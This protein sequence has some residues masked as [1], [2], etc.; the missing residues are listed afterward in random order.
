MRKVLFLH[1]TWE[2]EHYYCFDQ[3][4]SDWRA[5]LPAQFS[6]A[7]LRHKDLDDDNILPDSG[8]V[9]S[10]VE[11]D[12]DGFFL[13]VQHNERV[14]MLKEEHPEWVHTAFDLNAL[15]ERVGGQTEIAALLRI[16]GMDAREDSYGNIIAPYNPYEIRKIESPPTNKPLPEAEWEHI[17]GFLRPEVT[18][19][20]RATFP[21]SVKKHRLLHHLF[22]CEHVVGEK[23]RKHVEDLIRLAAGDEL[24]RVYADRD[25][26]LSI[27]FNTC[28]SITMYIPVQKGENLIDLAE[29]INEWE[30]KL[31]QRIREHI[32]LSDT[33]L[34][35]VREAMDEILALLRNATGSKPR[36]LR[37]QTEHALTKTTSIKHRLLT[38][39]AKEQWTRKEGNQ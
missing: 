33:P 23:Y 7:K 36:A 4:T 17:E 13:R 37:E 31:A 12:I 19:G 34:L 10:P 32:D 28:S 5:D 2:G 21:H 1:L 3:G 38:Q 16:A 24:R 20:W 6:N 26:E 18:F 9:T 27:S 22:T 11:L 8:W 35:S 39:L 14:W 30:E 15:P 29:R 25:R